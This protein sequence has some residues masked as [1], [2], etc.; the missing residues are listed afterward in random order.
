MRMELSVHSL[1]DLFDQLGLASDGQAID[2]FIALHRPLSE[3]LALPDAPFWS[4]AQSSF[5]REGWR[6][7]A[8][9]VEIID[10]L[11]TRLR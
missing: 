8:D 6:Q 9:W 7:D 10:Q 1:A 11:N 3:S 5:L 4:P 2:A